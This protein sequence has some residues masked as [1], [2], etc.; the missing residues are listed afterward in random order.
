VV[1][2]DW[3]VRY[4]EKLGPELV[5]SAGNE[6]PEDDET[7]LTGAYSS[8]FKSKV[9]RTIMM[10]EDTGGAD[11]SVEVLPNQITDWKKQ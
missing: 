11:T 3:P 4:A 9:A 1:P 8:A 5:L 10:G 6:K 7:K 2:K